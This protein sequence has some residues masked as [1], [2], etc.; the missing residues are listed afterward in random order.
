MGAPLPGSAPV[1]KRL[2]LRGDTCVCVCVLVGWLVGWCVGLLVG[3]VCA[4]DTVT[5]GVLPR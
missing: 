2:A 4:R 3:E 5:K 1:E